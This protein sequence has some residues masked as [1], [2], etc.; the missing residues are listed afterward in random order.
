MNAPIFPSTP[1]QI[2]LVPVT[3]LKPSEEFNVRKTGGQS[4]TELSAS[5]RAN[6][7]LQNLTAI[8]YN[9]SQH[10]KGKADE[11]HVVAGNRRLRAI[12]QLIEE[13]HLPDDYQV[14]VRVVS[15]DE[16][17]AASLAENIVREAMNPAD[18]V[19]A[20]KRLHED[21]ELSP[22]EIADRFGVSEITVQRRLK[23]ANVAPALL[24][25]YRAGLISQ[26][27]LQALALTDD[28]ALQVEVWD[29]CSGMHDADDIKEMIVGKGEADSTRDRIALF[30][31]VEAYEAAGGAVRRDL[32]ADN[33]QCWLSDSGLLMRL[34]AEKLQTEAEA[35][36]A[37]ENLKWVDVHMA[38]AWDVRNQYRDCKTSSR[39]PSASEDFRLKKLRREMEEINE[40]QDT[41]NEVDEYEAA[42]A[43]EPRRLAL[44]AEI[45][46]L[47]EQ[48][49]FPVGPDAARAGAFLVIGMDGKVEIAR[50]QL[51]RAEDT[52]A[53]KAT[54]KAASKASAA[55]DDDSMDD[56]QDDDGSDYPAEVEKAVAGALPARL[57]SRL[58]AHKSAVGQAY[59]ASH[60]G[61]ALCVLTVQLVRITFGRHFQLP[62][63]IQ[64]RSVD[65]SKFGD[66][67]SESRAISELET[68]RQAVL[69]MLPE[70]GTGDVD[71]L[72]VWLRE[73]PTDTVLQILAL[74]TALQFEVVTEN[75]HAT[76]GGNVIFPVFGI[77]MA[78]WWEPTRATFFDHIT[79]AQIEATVADVCD[80]AQAQVLAG[81]KGKEVA[82][83]RAE[84][85]VAGKR[86]LP[87]L[88]RGGE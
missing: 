28:H 14:P 2:L 13:G 69:D 5:I 10:V 82:A 47:E 3:S 54:A 40:K 6:G 20:F 50:H 36:K 42:D 33:G 41:L 15:A 31:G 37:G 23:L 70:G 66:D 8:R 45:E 77:D 73:Q 12:Q 65:L 57:V 17:T 53:G 75:A 55:A 87:E 44:E 79:R 18:Q 64:G 85:M 21:E 24:E 1:E 9:L 26:E 88:L 56:D 59:L 58:T 83:G 25:E 7:L 22:A 67:V 43:L 80:D 48:L 62:L 49:E 27:K 4:I 84:Q 34:A 35:L 29:N 51:R 11:Y 46:D 61:D 52:A 32:F 72:L 74:C 68:A 38:R 71:E 16:A 19:L 39:D 60:H 78:D 81:L 76:P 30:V 63:N 86:W